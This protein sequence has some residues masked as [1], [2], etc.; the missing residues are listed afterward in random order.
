MQCTENQSILSVIHLIRL[1]LVMRKIRQTKI[2]GILYNVRFV[3]LKIL[4]DVNY[5]ESS[6]L[7]QLK[8]QDNQPIP[9]CVPG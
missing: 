2:Q 7:K 4:K 3:F 5:E 8:R 6:R 9:P 1:S